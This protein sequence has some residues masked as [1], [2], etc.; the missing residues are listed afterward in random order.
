MSIF[1]IILALALVLV[2]YV[3]IP[4]AGA[5]L[6]RGQWRTFRRR[7]VDSSTLAFLDYTDIR[8]VKEGHSFRFFGQLEAIQGGG[9]IWLKNG[10]ISVAA[11]LEKVPIYIMPR[12]TFDDDEE[13]ML[14]ED[15]PQ[16]IPWRQVSSLP[17]GT[18]VYTSGALFFEDDQAVLHSLP[19]S[20]LLVVL[21]DGEKESLLRRSIWGGRQRNEYWN[22][23]T[24]ISL[25]IGSF[26]LLF[27]AYLLF[28]NPALSWPARITLTLSTAPLATLFPPGVIFLFLYRRAW[29]KARLLRGARDLQRLPLR[30]SGDDAA[31]SLDG[32][33]Y[34]VIQGG[35]EALEGM[36]DE[37]LKVPLR[38]TPLNNRSETEFTLFGAYHSG[39]VVRPRDPMAELLMI[40]GH[41]EDNAERCSRMARF[42]EILSALLLSLDL[43]P[44]LFLILYL[45]HFIIP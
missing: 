30:F 9:R 36:L 2:F 41:P 42:Y 43:A 31:A 23:F 45:S 12:H 13:Q 27:L 4:G 24:L 29:E 19:R 21:Y 6:V 38:S 16:R 15:Q 20:P 10:D 5:F 14:P 7:M 44:N 11:D 33:E 26:S 25:I 1:S 34:T 37:P 35:K 40:P 28:R 39:K 17:A 22:P 3:L 32:E 8:R 18:P